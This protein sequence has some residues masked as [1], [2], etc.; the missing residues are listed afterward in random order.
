MKK[1]K[2]SSS[3]RG[4]HWKG[5]PREVV[6]TACLEPP[7]CNK[8]KLHLPCSGVGDT[9][10]SSGRLDYRFPWVPSARFCLSSTLSEIRKQGGQG[11]GTMT[12]CPNP[13]QSSWE[14]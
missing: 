13:P 4:A 9:P 6:E 11:R 12:L 7:R 10:T 1:E 8:R 3:G 14:S 2:T 5:L